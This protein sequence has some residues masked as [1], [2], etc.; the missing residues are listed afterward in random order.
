L[1][2][3]G[4]SSKVTSPLFCQ[5]VKEL[6]RGG[7]SSVMRRA[8]LHLHEARRKPLAAHVALGEVDPDA[9]DG[10]GQQTLDLQLCWLGQ[11]AIGGRLDVLGRCGERDRGGLGKLADRAL[12]WKH[13]PY[14]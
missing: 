9:L 1:S 8:D 4:S 7:S 12:A 2:L 11:Q 14:G 5:E 13:Q 10:A 6:L 3:C